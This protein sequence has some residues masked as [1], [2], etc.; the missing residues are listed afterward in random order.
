MC[1]PYDKVKKTLKIIGPLQKSLPGVLILCELASANAG[2]G[3]L[4]LEDQ[5]IFKGVGVP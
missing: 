1:K 4:T 3:D 5:K 2:S